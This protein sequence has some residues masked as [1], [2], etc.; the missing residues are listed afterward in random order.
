M[1]YIRR[2]STNRRNVRGSIGV[3][4]DIEGQVVVDSSNSILLPKGTTAERPRNPVNGH[5][6]FNTDTGE[7]EVYQDSEWRRISYKE[8]NR[9]PG[10]IMQSL[11]NGDAVET[12][13]GPLNNQ[14][15]DFPVP[16]SET[17]ILVFV[18]NV[19]QLPVTN[20]TLV[21]NPVGFDPGWYLNFGDAVPLGKPVT[22]LHNFDK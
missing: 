20:Y 14:D 11:G 18:E 4:Y 5:M 3:N 10:I 12:I 21:Q 8:P 22:V 13:F 1:R 6:R 15:A 2:Q 9:N 16:T 19:Y 7:F 17:H